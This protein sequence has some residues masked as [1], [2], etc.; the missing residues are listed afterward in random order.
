MPG[1]RTLQIGLAHVKNDHRGETLTI[2]LVHCYANFISAVVADV[3]KATIAVH[4]EQLKYPAQAIVSGSVESEI[5][6]F[7][8][9]AEKASQEIL[10]LTRIQPWRW[11]QRTLK[12]TARI[13]LLGCEVVSEINGKP[14]I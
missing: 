14:H 13:I 12:S 10:R 4:L 1:Y 6:D 9:E 2:L 11:R 5:L 3:T 7:G 8:F